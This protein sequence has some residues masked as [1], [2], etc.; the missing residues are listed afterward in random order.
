M[1]V[2]HL[3]PDGVA[4]IDNDSMFPSRPE[5]RSFSSP[6]KSDAARTVRRPVMTSAPRRASRCTICRSADAMNVTSNDIA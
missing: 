5:A 3:N 4:A 2:E 6:V 1:G